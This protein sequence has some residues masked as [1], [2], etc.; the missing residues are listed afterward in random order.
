MRR[1]VA[2]TVPLALLVVACAPAAA[3]TSTPWLAPACVHAVDLRFEYRGPENTR[4]NLLLESDPTGASPC[5]GTGIAATVVRAPAPNDAAAALAACDAVLPSVS[6]TSFAENGILEFPADAWLCN[7]D[8]TAPSLE[9][10]RDQLLDADG[11]D[12]TVLNFSATALDD[13][14]QVPA[15]CSPPSGSTFAVGVTTV[16]CSATDGAG[17]RTPGS[18]QVEVSDVPL[19]SPSSCHQGQWGDLWFTGRLG[20][21]GNAVLTVSRDGSCRGDA[22]AA[23]VVQAPDQQAAYDACDELGATFTSQDLQSVGYVSLPEDAW[24]CLLD[25]LPPE[26]SVAPALF[27]HADTAEGRPVAFSAV[28]VD[29]QDG[30]VPVVCDPASGSLFPVGTT[31]VTCRATDRTGNTGASMFEIHVSTDPLWFS[32]GCYLGWDEPDLL[33]TGQTNT[34]GNA[35]EY[36]GTNGGRCGGPPVVRTVVVAPAD[37][38]PAEALAVCRSVDP[39]A[40]TAE[41]LRGLNYVAFPEDGWRCS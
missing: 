36:A 4:D 3:P 39:A 20:T 28:A 11:P 34:L 15:V 37:S 22:G 12:G 31:S 35:R 8:T 13:G 40:T 32:G 1:T 38:T 9:L 14:R 2:A 29:A 24:Y 18:F 26:L 41:R 33:Y 10:P 16:E 23:T 27:V 25:T 7:P 17:L 30:T 21:R 6:A 5:D 19:W